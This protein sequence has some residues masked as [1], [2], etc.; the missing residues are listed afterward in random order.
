MTA[1]V[2]F[3]L[4]SS[5]WH[6]L[7][8]LPNLGQRLAW[9]AEQRQGTAGTAPLAWHFRALGLGCSGA[10]N[11]Q[12]SFWGKGAASHAG[13]TVRLAA[14]HGRTI[15]ANAG[16]I[17]A[18]SSFKKQVMMAA[19]HKLNNVK[20]RTSRKSRDTGIT[21]TL[22]KSPV[23][24]LTVRMRFFFQKSTGMGRCRLGKSHWH[25]T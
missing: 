18:W 2:K 12:A 16:W 17:C 21:C 24:K 11:K 3:W 25:C 15:P 13:L 9:W 4:S 22:W 7:P 10:P 5:L 6:S 14:P 20:G 8:R 1:R 23:R 19:T